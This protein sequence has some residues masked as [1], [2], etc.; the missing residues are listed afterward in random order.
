MHF[1][2]SRRSVWRMRRNRSEVREFIQASE[3]QE[4]ENADQ[5]VSS[6]DNEYQ[7]LEDGY[8]LLPGGVTFDDVKYKIE[9]VDEKHRRRNSQVYL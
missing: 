5:S 6:G 9:D 7:A 2:I 4:T 1:I 3:R 8:V